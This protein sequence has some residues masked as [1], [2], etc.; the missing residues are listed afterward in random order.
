MSLQSGPARIMSSNGQ[1]VYGLLDKKGKERIYKYKK[2]F[3]KA[4]LKQDGGIGIL[5][6]LQDQFNSAF[7]IAGKTTKETYRPTVPTRH[8]NTPPQQAAHTRTEKSEPGQ[9]NKEVTDSKPRTNI[10]RK[11]PQ[12]H[13]YKSP[14]GNCTNVPPV[15]SPT[16][17]AVL[18]KIPSKQYKLTN[19]HPE[20]VYEYFIPSTRRKRFL[21]MKN[22]NPDKVYDQLQEKHV[23]RFVNHIIGFPRKTLDRATGRF[24]N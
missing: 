9:P 14:N 1:T 21:Q 17:Q 19:G 18:P 20:L 6:D 8:V 15:T 3:E 7:G 5:K 16:Q 11:C 13:P 22:N 24:I 10:E 2:S 4:V 12:T 23:P